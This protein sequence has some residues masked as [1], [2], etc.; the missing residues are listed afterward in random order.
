MRARFRSC[1]LILSLAGSLSGSALAQATPRPTSSPPGLVW[2]IIVDHAT[3]LVD[4]IDPPT[5]P[6][7]PGRITIH[8]EWLE[9]D[10][11]EQWWQGVID[12]DRAPKTITLFVNRGRAKKAL[13]SYALDGTQLLSFHGPALSPA[14]GYSGPSSAAFSFQTVRILPK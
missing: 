4:E 8:Y 5:L 1:L 2:H 12:G 6:A 11:I 3:Y 9:N 14:G 7:P 10:K 13:I